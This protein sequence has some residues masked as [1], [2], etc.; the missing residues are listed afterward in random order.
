MAMYVNHLTNDNC[1]AELL[2]LFDVT[3]LKS[4]RR[5]EGF[6]CKTIS[7]KPFGTGSTLSRRLRRTGWDPRLHKTNPSKVL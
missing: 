7:L 5:S 6:V 3:E 4:P 2:L 1:I